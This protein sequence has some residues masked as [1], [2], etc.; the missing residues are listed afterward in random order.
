MLELG[1]LQD[2]LRTEHLLV[3]QAVE[4]NLFSC[5]DAA[6]GSL[7]FHSSSESGGSIFISVV[8]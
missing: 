5:V 4:L 3:V 6:E 8:V 2:A 7:L 1:V